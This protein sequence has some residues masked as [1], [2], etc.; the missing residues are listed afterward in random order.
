M[1]GIFILNHC[2]M[3]MIG[4]C[5][6]VWIAYCLSALTRPNFQDVYGKEEGLFTFR[7]LCWAH[8]YNIVSITCCVNFVSTFNAL[9]SRSYNVSNSPNPFRRLLGSWALIRSV[10]GYTWLST[11]SLRNYVSESTLSRYSKIMS[12]I[13]THILRWLG[14]VHDVVARH[15]RT[16]LVVL[17]QFFFDAFCIPLS[18]PQSHRICGPRS[19]RARQNLIS[20]S[21]GVGVHH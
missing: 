3:W 6:T 19:F 12:M 2:T 20:A 14:V 15:G 21:K 8:L 1:T 10:E 11:L 4:Q 13:M 16:V 5:D 17:W 7:C 18:V 9:F